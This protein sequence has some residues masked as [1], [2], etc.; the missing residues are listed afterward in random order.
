MMDKKKVRNT[1]EWK[2]F[3]ELIR[4]TQKKDPITLSRLTKSF[5]LHHCDLDENN[6]DKY[7]ED[8]MLG[9]NSRSHD[10]VHLLFNIKDKNGNR[11][12]DNALKRLKEVLDKMNQINEKDAPKS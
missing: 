7:N 3:R 10:V 4:T 1:K 2:A 5:H 6:Y 8:N 12:Y 11:D 9:L